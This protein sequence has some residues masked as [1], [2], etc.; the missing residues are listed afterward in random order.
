[1][2]IFGSIRSILSQ[3]HEPD[4]NWNI[5]GSEEAIDEIFSINGKPQVIYKHSYRCSISLFSKN[6]LDSEIEELREAADLH[7]IDVVT[8]RSLSRY[9]AEKSGIRHESPQVILLNAGKPF[10]AASHGDVRIDAL[11]DALRELA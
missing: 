8:D 1:M 4:P 5:P 2:G 7:L 3:Q 9:V 6:R 11:R 10:W